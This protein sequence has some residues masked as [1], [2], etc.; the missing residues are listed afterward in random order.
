MYCHRSFSNKYTLKKHQKTAKYCLLLRDDVIDESEVI[1]CKCCSK[2]FTCRPSLTRHMRTCEFTEIYQKYE[3]EQT[4]NRATDKELYAVK[5][6][7]KQYKLELTR[8]HKEIH[9]LQD[10][11][12]NIAI[13]GANKETS[14]TI[15]N[16]IHN[17][18]PITPELL[19]EQSRHLTIEHVHKGARWLR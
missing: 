19:E 18:D 10:K 8:L 16:I 1:K 7:N 3:E 9:I 12:E 5:T 6:L 11:L 4:K 14:T 2:T 15:N 17:L 13:I